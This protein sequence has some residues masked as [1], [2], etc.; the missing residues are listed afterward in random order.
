MEK[1]QEQFA[2]QPKAKKTKNFLQEI[3]RLT[4]PKMAFS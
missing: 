3:H 2:A 4:A 1:V